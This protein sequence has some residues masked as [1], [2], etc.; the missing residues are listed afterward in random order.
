M[1]KQFILYNLKDDVTDED[2]IEWCHSFKGPLLLGLNS[3]K[4]FTLVK[5]LGGRKGD[6]QK[7]IPPE[8]TKS[9]FRF[10]GVMDV[11]SKEE[12][13]K[14]VASKTYQEDFFKQ[15]FS[16]WGADFYAI[17]GDEVYHGTND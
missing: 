2:Y 7:G 8:E 11:K 10:I 14:D 9:P 12:W 6:G 13:M 16:K 17:V 3:V 4:S 1:P 15:W 5:M